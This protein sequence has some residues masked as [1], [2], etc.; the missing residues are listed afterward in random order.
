MPRENLCKRHANKRKARRSKKTAKKTR[1]AKKRQVNINRRTPYR[2]RNR[3]RSFIP[4]TN[5]WNTTRR[6]TNTPSADVIAIPTIRSSSFGLASSVLPT[7][8]NVTRSSISSLIL[9]NHVVPGQLPDRLEDAHIELQEAAED[10]SMTQQVD[11]LA[12]GDGP[13]NSLSYDSVPE[14]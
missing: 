5:I 14:S 10:P 7:I 2:R 3:L 12:G 6:N 13:H 4:A 9:D 1:R 11:I 8:P